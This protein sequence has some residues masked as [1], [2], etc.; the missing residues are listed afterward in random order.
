MSGLRH[1]PLSDLLARRFGRARGSGPLRYVQKPGRLRRHTLVAPLRSG[2]ESFPA[3]LAAIRAA[4]SAIHFETYIL[5][6]DR[7]GLEFRDALTERAQAGVAVRLLYDAV[8]SLG[9]PDSFLAP[10]R[11]AGGRVAVFHPVAPWRNLGGL[12]SLNQ[13]DHK[14]ILVVDDRVGFTGGINVG[15]EYVPLEQGGGGWHDWHARLE[16]PAVFELAVS[17]RRTWIKASG[18]WIPEAQVPPPALGRNVLGVQIV[19]NTGV[20]SRWRMHR[21]YL[22]AIGAATRDISILNAYFIPELNL[23]RAF[24]RAV[25]RGVSVRIIVPSETDV[26][27]V[28]HASRYLYRRLLAAGVRLFE[29]PA[30][31]MHAKAGIIDGVWSTIGS[32]NLDHRS[33]VHNLEVGLVCVD[34]GLAARLQGEF[35]SDLARCREVAP[36]D[37]DALSAWERFKDWFWYQLRSQL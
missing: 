16:G 1:N 25:A 37:L 4:R 23:R 7:V 30:G 21:A 3:M 32:Y 18:E 13:R 29:W 11:K 24:R 9:L 31:M 27:P 5:R 28:R 17:F 6:D 2:G 20:R 19:D 35:E 15:L 14:K 26:Q 22:H 12:R 8:G 10:L 34:E 36:A 33:L